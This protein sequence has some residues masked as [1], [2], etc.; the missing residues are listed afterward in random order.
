[1][2]AIATT[3]GAILTIVA[4]SGRLWPVLGGAAYFFVMAICVE[5]RD[6]KR[7]LSTTKPRERG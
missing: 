7:M 1:M 6:L 3:C 4:I 2:S 5:I